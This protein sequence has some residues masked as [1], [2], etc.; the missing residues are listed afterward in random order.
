MLN[1]PNM[2]MIGGNSRNSG[3]TTMACSIIGKLSV[4][5]DV[6]GL[7]VTSICPGED[8][9]H[10][11]HTEDESS[12]FS[13]FEE[14]NP[15]SDK[16]T[17]RMLRAGS[18]HVYYIRVSEELIE[19][20]LLHF[21]STYIN[22]QLIVC[23]S[24]SLR[25]IINPGLFLMMMRLPAVN[26]RKDVAA[27]LTLADRVFYFDEDQDARKQFVDSLSFTEGKFSQIN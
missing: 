2:V 24:R 16:D 21:L 11:H 1:V 27:Y 23:E 10:G 25:G 7:K 19:K 6:I 8:D 12:G 14:L 13:I 17:S 20:T 22:K 5:E 3:K 26:K 15:G 4:T 18:S 9:F